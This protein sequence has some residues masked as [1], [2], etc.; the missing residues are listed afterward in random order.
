MVDTNTTVSLTIITIIVIT[1][2]KM[3]CTTTVVK[4]S[5]SGFNDT[6]WNYNDIMEGIHRS[7][8]LR[9]EVEL[10]GIFSHV[11]ARHRCTRREN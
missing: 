7:D 2:T 3:V 11:A 10:I 6:S 5:N 8:P 9:A 1:A 4:L